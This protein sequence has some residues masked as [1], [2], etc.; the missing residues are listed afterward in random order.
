MVRS[1]NGLAKINAK[2]TT[3]DQTQQQPVG[4]YGVVINSRD[5]PQNKLKILFYEETSLISHASLES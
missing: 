1:N 4:F 2:Q 5:E 3:K